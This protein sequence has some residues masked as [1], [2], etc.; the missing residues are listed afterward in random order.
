MIRMWK[1]SLLMEEA[2]QKALTPVTNNVAN[3]EGRAY[4]KNKLF[5]D[6]DNSLI[7][8]ILRGL[9]EYRFSIDQEILPFL[10]YLTRQDATSR[11]YKQPIEHEFFIG[12][13]AFYFR[14]RGGNERLTTLFK[15]PLLDIKYPHVSDQPVSG[16]QDSVFL[17]ENSIL[18]SQEVFNPEEMVSIY[19]LDELFLEEELGVPDNEIVDFR[20]I[21]ARKKLKPYEYLLLFYKHLLKPDQ[22]DAVTTENDL[23]P[24]L[25]TALEKK[26]TLVRQFS[27]NRQPARV[28]PFALVYELESNQPTRQLQNDLTDLISL[29]D[30]GDLKNDKHPA[31]Y[32]LFGNNRENGFDL[33]IEGQ[34]QPT[35]LTDS[36]EKAVKAALKRRFTVINGPPGTGKTHV[37]RNIMSA[38]LVRFINSLKSPDDRIKNL[39]RITLVT[40]T[41]NR[42]V[43]NALEGL[44]IDNLLPASLR[45][46]SRIILASVTV[47]FLKAY[48]S[49]LDKRIAHKA[50]KDFFLHQKELK[51][52]IS[53][54]S[55]DSSAHRFQAY[56]IAR[57]T[58]DAWAVCNKDKL[59]KVIRSLIRDIEERRGLYTL[60]R[61]SNFN[62]LMT[63]FPLIGCT[64]LSIRNIF[65]ME[66]E[67][68]GMMIVDEA[69]QCSP[70]YIF[71][72][73][74]RS[75]KTVMIGD[76]NQLEPISSLRNEDIIGQREHRDIQISNDQCRFFITSMEDMRSAQHVAIDACD[77]VLQLKDHFRCQQNIIQVSMDLCGYDLNVKTEPLPQQLRNWS[78]LQFLEVN[79]N[80]KRYGGS[81]MNEEEIKKTVAILKV[82][83]DL[84]FEY[85]DIAI[86]T[87]FRGQLNYINLS[88]KKERIPYMS[89]ESGSEKRN[90]VTT[91]TV[92]R[93]QGGERNVVLFSHVI[94]DGEPR[95]LNSRVNLLNVAVSRAQQCFIFIGSLNA[96]SRGTY[97][98]LLKDRLLQFG[99]S[100]N[101]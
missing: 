13:P 71:P 37:I 91:G 78:E 4:F 74:M 39:Y 100:V 90:A 25:I 7:S 60:K 77:D 52:I 55:A 92:H 43:D 99:E 19:W 34:Y 29:Y 50:I 6:M 79:G 10:H 38:R 9:E 80:E 32:Y 51:K 76:I 65:P 61:P 30:L 41:N 18:M 57:K 49:E 64:L 45:V 59:L 16:F 68:I 94:A 2:M 48:C 47:A 69:G 46:G 1:A 98:S 73:M 93:F 20:R 26:L 23:F 21:C 22:E 56:L 85:K 88:L 75:R 35:E 95:F 58:L 70:S 89:G 44:G 11:K 84:G 97:T 62:L 36:Q 81:W 17:E 15:F 40:S 31:R 28:F 54:K 14:D 82:L 42:A 96:L 33:K 86:L 67:S 24:L 5:P 63:A 12:F 66:D 53:E 87:P 83:H 101:I 27:L 3:I 8:F 72:G